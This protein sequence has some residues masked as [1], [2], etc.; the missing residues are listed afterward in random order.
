M[1]L[2]L[3]DGSAY[4]HRMFHAM[5]PLSRP[6]DDMPVG[7]LAGVA[8][9][10]LD[11]LQGVSRS[12]H[13]THLAVIFDARR[14]TF[15]QDIY[16]AY[17]ANRSE[18]HL[19]LKVQMP[20]MRR[21]VDALGIARYELDGFEADDIIA[22]YARQT[23]AAGGSCIIHSSD[24]DLLQLVS[25]QVRCY[26]AVKKELR[27]YDETIAK[28]GV[29]P[30]MVIDYQALVG[31]AVDNV[32]GVHK[33]GPGT[34]AK[35]LQL[36]GDL[37]AILGLADAEIDACPALNKTQRANLKDPDQRIAARVSRLL[38]TLKD[39]VPVDCALD[40]FKVK[41]LDRIRTRDFFAEMAFS[42]L[43]ERVFGEPLAA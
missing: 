20:H 40:A 42:A 33:I 9:A 26:C 7:A 43:T 21:L 22:T 10:L 14:A 6:S 36:Y 12:E 13:A 34:A 28:L 32:P 38:V 31:D 2:H 25:D 15:R 23:E 39:D 24:K 16:P 17:K 37:D 3:V 18:M 30:D 1:Q 8:G 11:I 35:L 27:G 4:I 29:P 41:P 5:P 19:D